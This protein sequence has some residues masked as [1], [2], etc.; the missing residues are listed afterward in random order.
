[1]KL[2]EALKE[3]KQDIFR[4]LSNNSNFSLVKK[5]RGMARDLIDELTS[6]IQREA[7]E[8]QKRCKF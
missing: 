5:L 6:E 7:K 1:M 4:L 2:E 8:I 3:N